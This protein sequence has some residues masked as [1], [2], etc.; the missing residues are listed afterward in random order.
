MSQS[1]AGV[2]SNPELEV[3]TP[4]NDRE[5]SNGTVSGTNSTDPNP[6]TPGAIVRGGGDDDQ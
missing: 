5:G 4:D 1:T 2:S 3:E 6:T